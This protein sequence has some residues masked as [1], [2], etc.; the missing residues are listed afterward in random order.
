MTVPSQMDTVETYVHVRWVRLTLPAVLIVSSAAFLRQST[1]KPK[2]GKDPSLA[3]I[4]RGLE[5]KGE[6][7]G[8]VN[9]LS[10]M[11]DVVKEM[12]VRLDRVD[13]EDWRLL[14]VN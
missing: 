1:R 4:F 12:N 5:Q 9:K 14:R 11:E 2:Y 3:L 13:A 10:D 7:S 6:I 8:M